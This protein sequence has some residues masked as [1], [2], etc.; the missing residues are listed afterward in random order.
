MVVSQSLT[1]S[2]FLASDSDSDSGFEFGFIVFK[3]SLTRST[4]PLYEHLFHFYELHA[5]NFMSVAPLNPLNVPIWEESRCGNILHNHPGTTSDSPILKTLN[6]EQKLAVTASPDSVLQILAGPGTG[7]TTALVHRTAWLVNH[8]GIDPKRIILMTFTNQAAKQ[9]QERINKLLSICGKEDAPLICGTFHSVCRRYLV[10]HGHLIGLKP[11]FTIMDEGAQKSLLTKIMQSDDI[12]KISKDLDFCK[13]TNG[14]TGFYKSKK[15]S[16]NDKDHQSVTVG[17]IRSLMS[18]IRSLTMSLSEWMGDL[19]REAEKSTLVEG[20]L[21]QKNRL[22]CEVFTRYQKKK[23]EKNQLDFDDI[24]IYTIQLLREHPDVV[25]NI[26]N[27]LIDEFQDSDLTQY[28][29]TNLFAQYKK[30]ITVVGDPDQAIYS[31]RNANSLNFSRMR[32]QYPLYQR[33]F[34]TRNYRSTSDIVSFA[35][36]V[37]TQDTNRIDNDRILK[38]NYEGDSPLKASMSEFDNTQRELGAIARHIKFLTTQYGHI[39]RYSDFVILLRYRH[40]MKDVEIALTKELI[41]YTVVGTVVFWERKEIKIFMQFLLAIQSNTA[42]DAIIDSIQSMRFG[43]GDKQ[44]G[45]ILTKNNEKFD[46]LFEKLGACAKNSFPGVSLN[47][48]IKEGISK[49]LS[50]IR[51]GRKFL[52]TLAYPSSMAEVY[53]LILTQGKIYDY[54]K[55]VAPNREEIHKEHFNILRFQMLNMNRQLDSDS[56]SKD[57]NGK[58]D[59]LATFLNATT[60]GY[61]NVNT[62]WSKIDKENRVTISTIHA[63]KGLEWPI[64]FVPRL[65]DTTIHENGNQAEERRAFYVSITRGASAC[66]LSWSHENKYNEDVIRSK[67]SYEK[68]FIPPKAV[69][70]ILPKLFG[71]FPQVTEQNM[72]EAAKFLGRY[73]ILEEKLAED[74]RQSDGSVT[75][76]DLDYEDE[77]N[78]NQYFDSTW[79]NTP[80]YLSSQQDEIK[81][82]PSPNNSGFTT[83]LSALLEEQ[84]F[85]DI[86]GKEKALKRKMLDEPNNKSLNTKTKQKPNIKKEATQTLPQGQMTFCVGPNGKLGTKLS[87]ENNGDNDNDKTISCTPTSNIIAKK[88]PK[89]VYMRGSSVNQT[90][91]SS[92]TT[93]SMH[94]NGTSFPQG[95]RSLKMANSRQPTTA[96]AVSSNLCST[97]LVETPQIQEKKKTPLYVSN[98]TQHASESLNTPDEK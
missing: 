41:P 20:T 76:D 35:Q 92:S 87:T 63:A 85:D 25:N 28:H 86:M 15:G 58:L 9:L 59:Y 55:V 67:Q 69:G 27:I 6:E 96:I 38:A 57:E 60:L 56:I 95:T 74:S 73:G 11:N 37:I 94:S 83:G 2:T 32:T 47:S 24:L 90:T 77:E 64:V 75:P 30:S 8:Y 48:K 4:Y 89:Y 44:M 53:N 52:N 49:Y 1:T 13:I 71:K 12:F 29:L 26:Q 16:T 40:L 61:L 3:N 51:S 66:Y 68:H 31:F 14:G 72:K 7:K 65:N 79:S 19:P 34:L 78:V 21:S 93:N 62:E 18:T 36:A 97:T 82:S 91:T 42:E 84:K 80:G 43:L 33:V 17:T 98:R 70:E 22:V 23:M 10:M 39:I 81:I 54:L 5:R 50:I 45:N 46:N 88:A